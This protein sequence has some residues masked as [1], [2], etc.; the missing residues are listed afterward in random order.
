M[1]KEAISV[2]LLKFK[3]FIL[4]LDLQSRRF[5][6]DYCKRWFELETQKDKSDENNRLFTWF[7]NAHQIYLND[8]ESSKKAQITNS[9][10]WDDLYGNLSKSLSFQKLVAFFMNGTLPQDDIR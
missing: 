3:N 7:H 5:V 9:N 4:S 2:S 10:V 1:E 6:L 8:D